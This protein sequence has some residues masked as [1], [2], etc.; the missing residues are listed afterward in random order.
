PMRSATLLHLASTYVNLRKWDLC[1]QTARQYLESI[2]HLGAHYR[3]RA[4]GLRL[5]G[6]ARLME[7]K[8]DEAVRPFEEA[9]LIER[10]S[11]QQSD[12]ENQRLTALLANCY[13]DSK[14]RRYEEGARL[15]ERQYLLMRKL[16]ATNSRAIS[17][18]LQ[19]EHRKQYVYALAI[20]GRF[21]DSERAATIQPDCLDALVNGCGIALET[22]KPGT[23]L[24]T[25]ALRYAKKWQGQVSSES[26]QNVA[27][28]VRKYPSRGN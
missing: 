21:E 25:D 6:S 5:I 9:L 10:E 14:V 12:L 27:R 11:G 24:W 18:V 28:E 20:V 26:W 13:F 2:S 4:R 19:F 1:E 8:A 17:G 22:T 7:H 3:G 23:V 15:A 16:L